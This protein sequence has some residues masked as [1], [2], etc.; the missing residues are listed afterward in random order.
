ME[1]LNARLVRQM[2]LDDEKDEDAYSSESATDYKDKVEY[3]SDD[4]E[5]TRK[6]KGR[7]DEELRESDLESEGEHDE[8][9]D[10]IMDELENES[11]SMSSGE[12][13]RQKEKQKLK[14]KRNLA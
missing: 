8:A 2:F 3:A 9:D 6:K 7:R 1:A 11:L 4:E 10:V 5:G 14:G 13:R 12:K